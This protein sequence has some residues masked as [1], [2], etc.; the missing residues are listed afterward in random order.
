MRVSEPLVVKT[1]ESELPSLPLVG[2]LYSVGLQ[3]DSNPSG[4]ISGKYVVVHSLCKHQTEPVVISVGLSQDDSPHSSARQ[5]PFSITLAH[6][7]TNSSELRQHHL[8]PLAY[9]DACRL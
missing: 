7:K 6:L 8:V 1:S 9:I 3:V 4:S 5:T 2:G